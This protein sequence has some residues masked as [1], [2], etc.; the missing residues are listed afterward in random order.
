MKLSIQLKNLTK[1]IALKHPLIE[2]NLRAKLLSYLVSFDAT[3]KIL[4]SNIGVWKTPTYKHRLSSN[5][6]AYRL[7]SVA[8]EKFVLLFLY[9]YT[10]TFICV[11]LIPLCSCPGNLLYT[12]LLAILLIF[13]AQVLLYSLGSGL[14]NGYSMINNISSPSLTRYLWNYDSNLCVGTYIVV[15]GR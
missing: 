8:N 9:L 11:G 10:G 14:S 4:F 7:F 15:V 6:T 2:K 13:H 5:K 12:K 3:C 1:I